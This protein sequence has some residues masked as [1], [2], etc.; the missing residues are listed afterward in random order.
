VENWWR[1][2]A[3]RKVELGW[4]GSLL[5]AVTCVAIATIAR[6]FIGW[7]LGPTLLFATFFPAVLGAALFGGLWAGLFSI[8][9]SVVVVW[10]AFNPPYFQFQP[11]HF[12]EIADFILFTASSLLVLWLAIA[13]RRLI[14]KFE[15]QEAERQLLAGEIQH[16]G[17][18]VLAVVEVLIRQTVND[19]D[20][21]ATLANRVRA[22]VSTQDLL[23]ASADNTA[24]LRAL[25]SDELQ[26]YGDRIKLEGPEVQFSGPTARALRLVFHEMA[27]N[28]LKYGSLSEATGMVMVDWKVENKAA[29]INWCEQDGP[30][31]S[32]PSGYN[33]GS[34][35][36]VRTL[37]QLHADFEPNFAES[38]YCYRLTVPLAE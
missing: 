24:N 16:R 6:L 8:P 5:L 26:P 11:L 25:L 12:R 33:F 18:N 34:K 21:A 17:R 28:A 20:L 1:R 15:Q 4:T 23:D 36:I 37:K 32:A 35:L 7:L 22:I 9:L 14:G 30:K 19:K 3:D 29:V 10:W 27:T 31:T 38:G 2:F 13:H